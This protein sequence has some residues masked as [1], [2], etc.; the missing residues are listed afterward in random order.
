MFIATVLQILDSSGSGEVGVAGK[1]RSY[2]TRHLPG[3]RVGVGQRRLY[4]VA[5]IGLASAEKSVG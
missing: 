4:A 5:N 1:A 2:H 3:Y